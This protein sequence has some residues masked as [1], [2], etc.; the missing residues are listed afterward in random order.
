MDVRP[1]HPAPQRLPIR[2]SLL[3]GPRCRGLRREVDAGARA[4][5]PEA[6]GLR[7]APHKGRA[8]GTHDFGPARA[9]RRVWIVAH[10]YATRLRPRGLRRVCL[11]SRKL[12]ICRCWR[13]GCVQQVAGR[14]RPPVEP[15]HRH[16]IARLKLVEQPA[17]LGVVRLGAARHLAEHLHASGLGHLAYLCVNALAFRRDALAWSYLMPLFAAESSIFVSVLILL[18][19]T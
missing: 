2:N 8:L 4:S 3:D 9:G 11:A 1:I 15:R 5:Q 12:G 14:S 17:K 13:Q 18:R 10:R 19:N 7:P 6:A 16:H